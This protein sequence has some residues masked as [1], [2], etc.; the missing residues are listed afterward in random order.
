MTQPLRVLALAG[1]TVAISLGVAAPA[2]AA[3]PGSVLPSSIIVSAHRGGAAYAPEDTMYAYRNAVRIGA[4]QMETDSW[5]TSDGVLVLIHDQT[6]NRT[7]NCTGNVTDITFAQLQQQCNAGWWWTPGQST[8]SADAGK[9]HPLRNLPADETVRV[10]AAKELF[11]FIGGLGADDKHTINIEIK[12]A[13][14]KAPTEALVQLI[15]DEDKKF[16]GLKARTIVQSFYPPALDYVKV[17][18]PTIQ[19]ALLTE[20]TTSP[21][22]AWSLPDHH[23]WISPSNGDVDLNAQTVAAAH[24]AGKKVIPWTP[25]SR[26]DLT[27]MGQ[28][29]VDGLITNYPAC[30]L[31]LEG[32][33]FPAQLLPTPSIRAG[34]GPVSL[35]AGETPTPLLPEF[36]WPALLALGATAVAYA[37]VVRRRRSA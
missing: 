14:F 18:D 37:A 5:L 28:L 4:D 33:P 34:A 31:Q 22:L 8:T 36:R 11:D 3:G 6:L 26:D 27:A 13:D 15:N 17:L 19:T 23:E 21:Y 12:D 20:G 2:V 16:P 7:T 9:P 24:N 30:L 10:P 29:G 25:D 1:A 35:C 32:R